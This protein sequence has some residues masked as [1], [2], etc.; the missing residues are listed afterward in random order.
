MENK[1]NSLDSKENNT[2]KNTKNNNYTRHA[3]LISAGW[4]RRSISDE[5][6]LSELIEL[7]ESLGYEIHLESL[8]HELLEIL[9]E[10]CET[11][12]IDNW[13]KFK[14]IYTRNKN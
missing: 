14:V 11:C 12:Y 9:G 13:E 3:E 1:N 5:P 7:Y 2:E 4:V 8:S 6:R 10:K